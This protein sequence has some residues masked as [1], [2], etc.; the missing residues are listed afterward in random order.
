V[1]VTRLGVIKLEPVAKRLPPTGASYQVYTP[2]GAVGVKIAELPEQ[3][4]AGA[5]VGAAGP[6]VKVTRSEDVFAPQGPGGSADVKVR[7]ALVSPG[8]GV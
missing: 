7:V 3:I 8:P 6:G 5:T 1:F 2:P 4:R